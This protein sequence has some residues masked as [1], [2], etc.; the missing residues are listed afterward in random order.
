MIRQGFLK[1]VT[2]VND[3]R[4]NLGLTLFTQLLY[5]LDVMPRHKLLVCV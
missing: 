5:A 4:F 2:S 1:R 3:D